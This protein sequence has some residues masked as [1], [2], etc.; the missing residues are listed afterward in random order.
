MSDLPLS[1]T[2]QPTSRIGS[3]VP[4]PDP[5]AAARKSLFDHLVGASNVRIPI[6]S[7]QVFRREAGH[8]SE[9]KPAAIPINFRPGF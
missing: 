7:G 4:L 5:C 9:M 3:F 1:A 2:G 8:H 6:Y